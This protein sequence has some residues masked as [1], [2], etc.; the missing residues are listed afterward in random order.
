MSSY[1]GRYSCFYFERRIQETL[2]GRCSLVAAVQKKMAIVRFGELSVPFLLNCGF[3]WESS[4]KET[5]RVVAEL[6]SSGAN[7]R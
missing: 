6:A 5:M 2:V 3:F 7:G 1:C 4:R